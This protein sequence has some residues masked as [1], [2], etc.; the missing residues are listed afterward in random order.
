MPIQI[1]KNI[2]SGKVIPYIQSINDLRNV[3]KYFQVSSF[4]T[5][6][7]LDAFAVFNFLAFRALRRL[8]EEAIF[9]E[10]GELV[11]NHLTP[12]ELNDAK[13][14]ANIKSAFDLRDLGKSLVAIEFMD[15]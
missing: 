10:H 7:Y 3:T 6:D 1:R 4:S 9:E 14:R 5:D 8:D 11:L 12:G 13:I 15:Y 2:R